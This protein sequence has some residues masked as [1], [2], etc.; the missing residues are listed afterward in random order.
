[1]SRRDDPN[2]PRNNAIN[3]LGNEY[4]EAK[5]NYDVQKAKFDQE[6]IRFELKSRALLAF[7]EIENNLIATLE[8]K[9]ISNRA[10]AQDS[11]GTLTATRNREFTELDSNTH[12][13][14]AAREQKYRVI[15]D[16]FNR[17]SSS[18]ARWLATA[19][20]D[21]LIDYESAHRLISDNYSKEIAEISN[22]QSPDKLLEQRP[23]AKPQRLGF[24]AR[25]QQRISLRRCDQ[26]GKQLGSALVKN[27]LGKWVCEEHVTWAD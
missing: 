6:Q 24:W 14:R 25:R 2:K 26:C 7:Q 13:S 12:G 15:V 20:E 4:D 22:S 9:R 19:N 23:E 10:A 11:L 21:A 1:M 27:F 5:S 8:R 17:D 16:K 18:V 3:I